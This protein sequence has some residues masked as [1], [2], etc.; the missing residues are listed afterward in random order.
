[1][2]NATRE[3]TFSEAIREAYVE[4]MTRDPNVVMAGTSIQAPTFPHSK[5]LC[6]LFGAARVMDTPI[7][8]STLAL[9]AMGAAQEGLRP[10]ADFMFGG[11]SYYAASEICLA[12]GQ[13]Y[14]LHGSQ[15]PLPMVFIATCGTGRRLGEDHSVLPTGMLIH[16]PGV[17]VCMPSTPY[18]AKGLMKA[19]IRDNNPVYFLWNTGLMMNKG[20]VPD[21]DYV[22]PLGAADVKREGVD[23]TV[24]AAGMQTHHA[25]QA[26][27]HLAGEISV[28]VVDPRS[29]APFDLKTV[30][31]S[32]QK[33]SRLL[34]VDEDFERAGFAADVAAQVTEHAYDFLDA[35]VR[36]LCLPQMPIPGGYAEGN[37]VITPERIEAAVRAMCR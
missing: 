5:G 2:S 29:F 16:H 20:P 15:L 36:R 11:F 7:V 37:I 9:W 33:T 13:Y 17:K 3:L 27:E 25:L 14:L 24:L 1:M 30:L 10:I 23:V 32:V 18:D 6:E 35:P 19:A 31:G 8:E 12:S 4:E 34:V 28:E 21:E 26:A 22:V